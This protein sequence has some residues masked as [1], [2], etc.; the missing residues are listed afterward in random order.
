MKAN[1]VVVEY[2]YGT[3]YVLPLAIDTYDLVMVGNQEL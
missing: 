3:L 2:T 1:D